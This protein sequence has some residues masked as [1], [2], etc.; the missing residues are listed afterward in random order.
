MFLLLYKSPLAIDPPAV[1]HLRVY[2]SRQRGY[3]D[4]ITQNT[5]IIPTICEAD[6]W[7]NPV[8]ASLAELW[9]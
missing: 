2:T 6:W 9:W 1:S 4:S 3:T 8:Y 7:S 5:S